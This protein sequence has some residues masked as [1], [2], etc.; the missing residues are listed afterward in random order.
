MM[1]LS[2]IKTDWQS[3][4]GQLTKIRSIVFIDE[5]NVPKSLEIDEED[6]TATHFLV[7]ENDHSAAV[8][9][10][11][12]LDNGHIGRMAVLKA[13]RKQGVGSKL[14]TTIV[15]EAQNRGHDQ[16]FLHAQITAVGFY[17]NAGFDSRGE[18]FLDAGIQHIEMFKNLNQP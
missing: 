13:Y 10:A 4:Q 3:H 11:R 7:I 6:P 9:T 14:L 5:Q 18:Y 16:V 8:A 12:L 15:Q 1:N 2:I 17:E